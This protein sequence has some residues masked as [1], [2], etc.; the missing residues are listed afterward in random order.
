MTNNLLKTAVITGGHSFDVVNFYHLVRALPGI[1]GYIQHLDDFAASPDS[2]RAAYDAVLFYCM[3]RS[4]PSDEG[5]PWY[6][7]KLRAALDHLGTTKQGIVMLHHALVAFPDFPLWDEWVGTTGRTLARYDHDEQIPVTVADPDHPVTA[8]LSD[9]TL[10]DETYQMP[11][12]IAAGTHLLL[13]TD[14]AKSMSALAW[15][16]EIG[17]NRVFCLQSG[18]DHQTWQD[19]RFR[20]VL[21]QG[22]RWSAGG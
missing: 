22:I 8:G 2:V 4:G 19:A 1:D 20:Q 13:T 16:R 14:H 5:Q 17:G 11:E 21:Q 7:G 6:S 15:A 3:P 10:L 18:H 12:P 9:W